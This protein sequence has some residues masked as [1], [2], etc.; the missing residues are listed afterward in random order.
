MTETLFDRVVAESRLGRL[1]AP[2]TI[3]RLLVRS[4]VV[5][6]EQVTPE[7]LG[8]ALPTIER[9]LKIYLADDDVEAAMSSMRRLA[10][11]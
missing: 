1:V 9:G 5:P 11:G 10:G 6:P 3:R 4:D 7:Q 2:F 8:E